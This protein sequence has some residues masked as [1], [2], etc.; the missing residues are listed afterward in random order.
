[1]GSAGA[2]AHSSRHLASNTRHHAGRTKREGCFCHIR[3]ANRERTAYGPC[4][5][6][7]DI[8]QLLDARP[9][10][11]FFIVTSSGQRSRVDSPDHADINPRGSRVVVWFNDDSSVTVLGL[12][13]TAIEKQ[14]TQA[15]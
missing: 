3:F 7:A 9:F 14:A 4:M 2:L 1:M 11:P 10:E 5:M 12:H 15:A 13:I 6:I 8:R